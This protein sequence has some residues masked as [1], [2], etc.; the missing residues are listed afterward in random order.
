MIETLKAE[1]RVFYLTL[2]LARVQRRSH[3]YAVRLYAEKPRSRLLLLIA[4]FQDWLE[5]QVYDTLPIAAKAHLEI[6]CPS[7]FS[8]F[9]QLV[10][11]HLSD[12]TDRFL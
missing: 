7:S 9:G 3:A 8:W 6:S 2:A 1:H 11:S 12:S 4:H 10:H 5:I